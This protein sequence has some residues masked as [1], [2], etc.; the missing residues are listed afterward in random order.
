MKT[1]NY[2]TFKVSDSIEIE[3]CGYETRYS[4]GHIA[5]I[6]KNGIMVGRKKYTY[7]NRT[8]ERFTYESVMFSVIEKAS[9]SKEDKAMAQDWLKK[10]EPHNPFSGIVAV[11]MMGDILCDNQASK[12]DWKERM[13]KA[14]L[15]NQGLDFPEDWAQLSE[16]EKESRL[17]K[18]IKNLG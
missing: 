6:F 9:L 3:C 7:Y 14:G 15:E 8:W 1:N 17:D 10:Y 5:E 4:W 13:L 12:N 18:A 16:D 2:E 11:A